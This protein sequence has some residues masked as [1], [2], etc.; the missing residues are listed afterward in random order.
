MVG[1]N[2]GAIDSIELKTV[3]ENNTKI[4]VLCNDF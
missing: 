2:D 3:T 4:H 1:F